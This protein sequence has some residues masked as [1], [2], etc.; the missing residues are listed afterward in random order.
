MTPKEAFLANKTL[1]EEHQKYMMTKAA[2]A[3]RDA[4]LLQFIA[5]QPRGGSGGEAWD[6][7]SH[8]VGARRYIEIFFNL[9][10]PEEPQNRTKLPS[11]RPPA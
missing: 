1:K 4:A 11:L 2:D 3:A 7:H 8:L 6:S 10:V 9:H 5:E